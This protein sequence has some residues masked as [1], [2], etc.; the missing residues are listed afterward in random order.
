GAPHDRDRC[1]DQPRLPP[2]PV[3]RGAQPA[4]HHDHPAGR[5]DRSGGAP[6]HRPDPHLRQRRGRG[7]DRRRDPAGGP[8]R[9]GV[10][11]G[12][13]RAQLRQHRPQPAGAVHRLRAG[14]ARRRRRPPHQGGGRRGRGVRPGRAAGL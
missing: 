3:D 7:A 14:R 2:G 5:R 11:P 6:G 13:G 9:P 12:R 10:R 1:R 4:G 8:G